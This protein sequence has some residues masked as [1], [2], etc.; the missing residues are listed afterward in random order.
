[1]GIEK[2]C[3][4][5]LS[6]ARLLMRTQHC[7]CV[8][9][10]I[11]GHR[12]EIGQ[13][14]TAWQYSVNALEM[15]WGQI[16]IQPAKREQDRVIRFRLDTGD[17]YWKPDINVIRLRSYLSLDTRAILKQGVNKHDH[18]EDKCEDETRCR[19][20]LFSRGPSA[21]PSLMRAVSWIHALPVKLY[22]GMYSEWLIQSIKSTLSQ[23]MIDVVYV[24]PLKAPDE[25]AFA[26]HVPMSAGTLGS[27]GSA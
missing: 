4:E 24:K 21:Y 15:R 16:V 7:C 6:L 25:V 12:T 20:R 8:H 26:H 27:L 5:S 17:T 22:S 14:L 19:P 13:D 9:W 1:M 10:C 2:V 23:S 18:P 3:C 11:L